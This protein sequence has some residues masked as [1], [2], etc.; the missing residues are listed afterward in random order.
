[1]ARYVVRRIVAMLPLLVFI[2]SM[3]FIL[4]QYGAGDL[5]AYLTMQQ[6]GGRFDMER[7]NEM[8]EMLRLDDSILVRYGR[9]LSNTARGDLGVSYVKIGQ[10]KINWLIKRAIPVSGQLGL[11]AFFILIVIGI[12]LGVAAA[13]FQ[14]SALDYAIVGGSTLLSSIP[15]FVL[16]PIAMIVLVAELHIVPYVGVGWHGLF[17]VRTIL[18]AATLAAGPL[19]I[20]VRYTRFSVLEVLSQEYVRA[21]RARGLSEWLVLTRHVIKNSFTPILTVL[22]MTAA[23]LLAGSIFIERIFNL[24][25]FGSLA[26][27]ALEGGD[28]QTSTGVMLVSAVIMMVM[29]LIVDVSYGFL[30]PR[31]KIA[32]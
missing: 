30:D 10:P 1:M 2:T 22:G 4:G 23:Y 15:S 3:V 20:V 12:P 14:N 25:G 8:R 13:V 28:L 17:N 32:D 31:V 29:N 6:S 7:Y 11:A 18:P 21:A 19:L 26:A 9:W 5:A 27:E 16:A 24:S